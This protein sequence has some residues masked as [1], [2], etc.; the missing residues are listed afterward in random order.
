[1]DAKFDLPIEDPSVFG[2]EKFKINGRV[3]AAHFTPTSYFPLCC[4]RFYVALRN[5]LLSKK[6]RYEESYFLG[7]CGGAWEVG[8]RL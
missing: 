7:C 4:N 8:R 6:E 1:M 2:T 3:V 5:S